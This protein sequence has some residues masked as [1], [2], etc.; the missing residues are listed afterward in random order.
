MK[1]EYFLIG[2]NGTNLMKK[3]GA[4][5]YYLDS[6]RQWEEDPDLI[7][8]FMNGSRCDPLTKDQ[9]KVEFARISPDAKW[10]P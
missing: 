10:V 3:V 6:S 2:E 1:T 9:A 5:L 4:T 7:G 8:K